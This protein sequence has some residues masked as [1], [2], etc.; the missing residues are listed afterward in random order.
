MLGNINDAFIALRDV[1]L[2]KGSESLLI[3][4]ILMMPALKLTMNLAAL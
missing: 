4:Q 2:P 3:M 1:K